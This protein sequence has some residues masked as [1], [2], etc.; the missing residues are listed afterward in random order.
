M[1]SPLISR[2]QNVSGHSCCSQTKITLNQLTFI[3]LH[4]LFG[5][6]TH[7]KC[8]AKTLVLW[9]NETRKEFLIC[10]HI[11]WNAAEVNPKL[12]SSTIKA[13]EA[14][15]GSCRRT[16]VRGVLLRLHRRRFV[17]SG[18]LLSDVS[19]SATNCAA[20]SKP[21]QKEWRHRL[22]TCHRLSR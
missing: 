14:T 4:R 15:C 10:R 2:R 20:D 17:L 9:R 7:R 21:Q 13:S 19:V 6:L 3:V 12:W 8:Q 1:T 5:F 11:H 16:E 18:P 22:S